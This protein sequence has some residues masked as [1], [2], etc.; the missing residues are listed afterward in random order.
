MTDTN[1]ITKSR[2]NLTPGELLAITK[3]VL[4]ATK[5]Q[6]AIAAEHGICQSYVAKI[7]QDTNRLFDLLDR[8]HTSPAE[9]ADQLDFDTWHTMTTML[10]IDRLVRRR[11]YT[12]LDDVELAAQVAFDLRAAR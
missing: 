12:C 4:K 1:R 7:K 2:A 9:L 5:T 6:D 10:E 3:Q 11:G 8:F